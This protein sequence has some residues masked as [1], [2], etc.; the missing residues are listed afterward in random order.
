MLKHLKLENVGPSSAMELEFLFEY[1]LLLIAGRMNSIL[2]KLSSL[3]SLLAC[4]VATK[5]AS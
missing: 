2:M 3:T 1:D 5:H 4:S